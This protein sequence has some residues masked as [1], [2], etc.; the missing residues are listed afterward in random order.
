MVVIINSVLLEIEFVFC[1]NEFKNFGNICK[2][3][4]E[5]KSD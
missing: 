4:L 3:L 5:Y 2:F 1:K